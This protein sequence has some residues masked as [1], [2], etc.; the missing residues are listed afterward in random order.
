MPADR[1]KRV[2]AADPLKTNDVKKMMKRLQGKDKRSP[3]LLLLSLVLWVS[4]L[5]LTAL[6]AFPWNLL[7]AV[8][9][10]TFWFIRYRHSLTVFKRPLFWILFF[11]I[12]FGCALVMERSGPAWLGLS[13]RG[14][15]LGLSVNLH[16]LTFVTGL[17]VI[18]H[19]LSGPKIKKRLT[20]PRLRNLLLAM[21]AASQ[22]LPELISRLPSAKVFLRYPGSVL[23]YQ[24]LQAEYLLTALRV[25]NERHTGVI[26]ISGQ[27]HSGK[28][29]LL[30]RFLELIQDSD[31]KWGGFVCPA[32]F[33][34]AQRQGY[35]LLEISTG[36]RQAL[37]RKNIRGELQIGDYV[38]FPQA[39]EQGKRSLEQDDID[40][41][42]ILILDEIGPWEISG[43][44][45]AD[46]IPAV[47]MKKIPVRIFVVREPLMEAVCQKW[48]LTDPFVIAASET[49]AESLKERVL[50]MLTHQK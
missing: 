34:N 16:A 41:V 36:K 38:M 31:L 29:S 23:S 39:L 27:V 44:G 33:E 28:T 13:L 50:E 17:M 18:G 5:V 9:P 3:L 8:P 2:V 47:L 32:V 11:I 12:S 35:D 21:E 19:E 10:L 7:V 43:N 24:L 26:I 48:N 22:I 4:Y 14:I 37:A 1:A 40:A 42:D 45:W 6:L 30:M 15:W 49:S 25:S 46:S 20:G